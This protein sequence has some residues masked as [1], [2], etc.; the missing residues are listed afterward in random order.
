MLNEDQMECEL[1][2]VVNE[3]SWKKYS[4]SEACHEMKFLGFDRKEAEAY[5]QMECPERFEP[6]EDTS[7]RDQEAIDHYNFQ[8]GGTL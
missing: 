6:D 1:E 8:Y 4:L 7:P 2:A 3:F 5:L